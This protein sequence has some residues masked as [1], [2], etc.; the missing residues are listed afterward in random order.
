MRETIIEIAKQ[1]G[2]ELASR[3]G[4]PTLDQFASLKEPWMRGGALEIDVL[5]RSKTEYSFNVT[6]CRYAEMYQSLG[7]DDLGSLLSC[8]RD[9]NMVTGFNSRIKLSRTQTIMEGASHCDFR[10]TLNNPR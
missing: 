5:S 4:N 1:Q 8:A 2:A 7:M 6:R 10:Y 3:S 9:F